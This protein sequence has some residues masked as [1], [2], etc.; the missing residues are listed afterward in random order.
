[1]NANPLR[2]GESLAEQPADRNVAELD[3]GECELV[4]PEKHL[5][6]EGDYEA[7]FTHYETAPIFIKKVR[8]QSQGGKI[9]C[10][11]RLDPYRTSKL[12]PREDYRLFIAYNAASLLAPF[13]RN[14]RFRMTRGK[15]FVKDYERLIGVVR[16]RDRISPNN[17]KGK[18]LKVHV[19]TVKRD[20]NQ[21]EYGEAS[22]Y[23]VIDEIK[24]VLVGDVS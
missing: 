10:W 23:S 17:L 24:E 8:E 12:D 5:I 13:G 14:G 20:H 4:G 19:H 3:T 7:V 2:N 9:Y 18:L 15:K 22:Q 1:M 6:P 11:F 21:N 16:R